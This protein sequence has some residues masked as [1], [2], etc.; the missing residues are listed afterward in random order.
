MFT[1]DI[2]EPIGRKDGETFPV[3]FALHGFGGDELD[4]PGVLEI[5]MDRYVVV[6]LR[7]KVEYG[8]SYG[9]Y[10]MATEGE[11]SA[12]EIHEVSKEVLQFMHDIITKYDT[13]NEKDTF[14]VGFDQGA[15]VTLDLML[16]YGG[17]ISGAALLSSRFLAYTKDLPQNLLL[18]NTPFFVAHGTQDIAVPIEEAENLTRF[19][20]TI[21]NK[22]EFHSFFTG[23]HLK[24]AEEDELEIWLDKLVQPKTQKK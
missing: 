2:C 11:P 15:M 3:I 14:L 22:V 24:E 19:L 8:P 7:G 5:M 17:K 16:R 21:S 18:K 12:N 13:I 6:A 20:K 4:V 23:H 1:Y 10:H 9:F